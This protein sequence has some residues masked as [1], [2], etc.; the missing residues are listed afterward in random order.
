MIVKGSENGELLFEIGAQIMRNRLCLVIPYE[1]VLTA[2]NDLRLAD[3]ALSASYFRTVL[4]KGKR[5]VL[6]SAQRE[7][8]LKLLK[9]TSQRHKK[10]ISGTSPE[11]NLFLDSERSI[12]G[13]ILSI[14]LGLGLES[15]I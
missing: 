6:G 10:L 4:D 15:F 14:I 9:D 11:K 3:I 2:S 7:A 13:L 1:S 5:V 12:E 8:V